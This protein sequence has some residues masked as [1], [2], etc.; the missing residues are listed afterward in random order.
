MDGFCT[1]ENLRKLDMNTHIPWE[2][3]TYITEKMY[4]I[5]VD[6]LIAVCT[7]WGYKQDTLFLAVK[8][9][10]VFLSRKLPVKREMLQLYGISCLMLAVK[11]ME[12]FTSSFEYSN[13]HTLA[14]CIKAEEEVFSVLEGCLYYP[15]ILDYTRIFSHSSSLSLE[16]HK[17]AKSLSVITTIDPKFLKYSTEEISTAINWL[18]C[19]NGEKRRKTENG[20]VVA[21]CACEII[22]LCDRVGRSSLKSAQEY[23]FKNTGMTYKNFVNSLCRIKFDRILPSHNVIPK[24]VVQEIDLQRMGSRIAVLGEGTYGKVIKTTLD[25]K[26]CVAKKT[27]KEDILED[28]GLTAAYVRELNTYQVLAALGAEEYAVK[29]IGFNAKNGKEYLFLEQ[30]NF[31]NLKTFIDKHPGFFLKDYDL[32]IKTTKQ[33]FRALDFF[34][35]IG[36]LNR[37]I[38]PE[39][40]LVFGGVDDI[41]LKF[42]DFGLVRGPGIALIPDT[43]FTDPVC[44]LWYRPPEVLF[45]NKKD[46]I[47]RYGPAVDVWSLACVISQMITGKPL[48][49]GDSELDQGLKIFSLCGCPKKLQEDYEIPSDIVCVQTPTF[50]FRYKINVP[51]IITEILKKGLQVHP[52]ERITAGEAYELLENAPRDPMQIDQLTPPKK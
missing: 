30:A 24:K 20:R 37:D 22:G 18:V 50:P 38:K 40:I 48:F 16:D 35:S 17:K 11:R 46:K 52:H 21:T 27:R 33:L 19:V 42:C 26:V 31:G 45:P 39:N 1:L 3:Q 4:A 47:T 5:L 41:S 29:C 6:W 9:V 25:G 7:A 43:A 32:L 8:L 51:E 10:S 13:E 14:Q 36:A 2:K 12:V 49:P 44:T 15:T 28:E 34:H 23:V